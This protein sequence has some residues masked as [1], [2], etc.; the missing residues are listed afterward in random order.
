MTTFTIE[1]DIRAKEDRAAHIRQ[2][3]RVP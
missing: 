1:A 2:S 3:K